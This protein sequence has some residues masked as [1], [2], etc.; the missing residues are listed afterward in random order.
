METK[1]ASNLEK[2]VTMPGKESY[3]KDIPKENEKAAKQ[4]PSKAGF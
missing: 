4:I 1:F 3:R 2:S